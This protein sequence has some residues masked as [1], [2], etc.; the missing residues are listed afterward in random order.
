MP[1]PVTI[2]LGSAGM[3]G[4]DWARTLAPDL[5]AGRAV[6]LDLP[7]IDITSDASMRSGIPESAELVINCAAYTDVDGAEANEELATA[8]NGHAVGRLAARCRD[9]G[10]T[11]VHYST[12]YVFNG[13]ATAPYPVD[14]PRD[15]LGAYGRSKAVGEELL[16]AGGA[17]F[18]LLRT[19]WL[20]AAHGK[21]FVRTIARLAQ[22][23]DSLR[24]VDDQRGRPTST[25]TLISITRRLLDAGARGTFHACDGGECTWFGLAGE[26]ARAVNPAC[27]VA[28]CTTAE[29]PRPAPRPAYSVLDLAPTEALIGPIPHWREALTPVLTTIR[30]ELD[31]PPNPGA[32]GAV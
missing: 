24:V 3:L 20:Y 29:F 4:A 23:R 19:A 9:V 27:T 6:A 25:L 30:Q 12:D 11:L 22:E 13:R 17:E 1:V 21:N 28:P 32:S 14:A 7:D 18:L 2:L 10:A 26:I 8:I 15:P 31:A 16:E 5:D